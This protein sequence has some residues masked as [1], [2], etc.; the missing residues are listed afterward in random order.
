MRIVVFSDVH[1]NL[2][3]LEK[4]LSHAGR[5]DKYICLGDI[6]DYGP[7]SNEC[8][9]LVFSLPNCSVIEGNHEASFRNNFYAGSGISKAFFDFCQP[10]FGRHDQISNLPRTL[11]CCGYTFVHTIKD[12]NIY[13]DSEICLD[14]DYVVG[15]SHHQFK[16][17]NNGFVLYNAGSVGQNRRHIN[18]IN[19]LIIHSEKRDVEMKS[20]FYDEMC[21]IKEMQKRGY[22][23]ECIDYYNDKQRAHLQSCSSSP[24]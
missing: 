2:P 17:Q 11:E 22:P 12:K 7:W 13:P 3:A 20:L 14:R 4:M 23:R 5:A 19:Y 9:D 24:K 1:G 18:V 16:I 10:Q 15:H 8:V 6:V 21:V